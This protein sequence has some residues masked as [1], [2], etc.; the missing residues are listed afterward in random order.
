MIHPIKSIKVH[1]QT[2]ASK[3]FEKT[4]YGKRLIKLKDIH[5]GESCFVIGNGPSLKADDLQM[6]HNK[7]VLS[8]GTNRVFKIFKNTDWRP[9]F[10]VSE[11]VIIIK[12]I[13]KEISEVKSKAKYI[14][15]NL[16]WY[17]DVSIDGAD[18]FYLNS[19]INDNDVFNLSNNIPN[20]IT[21]RSTVSLTCLQLA[22]YMGF[23]KIYLLGVDHNFAKMVDKNGIVV[24]DKSIKDHFCD[25]YD[26]DI[27]HQSFAVDNATE[28]YID[29]ER[30]SRKMGTFKVYNA[31]RGGKLEVFQRVNFDEIIKEL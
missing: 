24:E 16:H 4:K 30:L 17:E 31:T 14:P 8:F 7:G 29:V 19:G 2:W 11:D 9:D 3:N 23:S 22:I 18:Y 12:G 25:S 28:A 13:Q 6:L 20:H 1:Y 21:C 27:I 10:Y 15:I 26:N 5:K